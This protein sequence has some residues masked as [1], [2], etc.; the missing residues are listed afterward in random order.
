MAEQPPAPAGRVAA[1]VVV[2]HDRPGEAD[3]GPRASRRRTA[4]GSGSGCR[5]PCAGGA[6]RGCVHV[7]VRRAGDVPRGVLGQ[8]GRLPHPVA[9][10]QHRHLA[11]V[12]PEL[13]DGDQRGRHRSILTDESA[14]A[15]RSAPT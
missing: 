6:A 14:R 7:D 4:A 15:T 10:V 8:A 1:P 9:D 2:H 12:G 11:E 13:R 3:T 5:P